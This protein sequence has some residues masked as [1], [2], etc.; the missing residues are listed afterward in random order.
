LI[1]ILAIV[2]Q[3]HIMARL[4]HEHVLPIQ[5]VFENSETKMW[6]IQTERCDGSLADWIADA[7]TR[8]LPVG[9]LCNLSHSIILGLQYLHSEG[10][11]HRDLKPSN[12][13]M[14]GSDPLIADFETSSDSTLG[15]ST[16]SRPACTPDYA[17]PEVL[18]KGQKPDHRSDLYCLGRVLHELAAA[19]AAGQL[20]SKTERAAVPASLSSLIKGLLDKDPAKRPSLAEILSRRLFRVEPPSASLEEALASSE[21][22]LVSIARMLQ[23]QS[24]RARMLQSPSARRLLAEA[25]EAAD[26]DADMFAIEVRRQT[27]SLE[28][29]GD[30]KGHVG[31]GPNV[32]VDAALRAFADMNDLRHKLRVTFTGEAGID[33]GGLTDAFYSGL[34]GAC[35][36]SAALFECYDKTTRFVLPKV[37]CCIV[38]SCFFRIFKQFVSQA[39]AD[40]KQLEVF[41]RVLI[42]MVHDRRVVSSLRRLPLCVYSFL[43]HGKEPRVS[44]GDYETVFGSA[45]SIHL[46]SCLLADQK[47]LS[48]DLCLS[49]DGLKEG[50]DK[51]CRVLCGSLILSCHFARFL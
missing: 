14:R 45:A 8:A 44:S 4:Q 48:D 7:K 25:Q 50:G 26:D 27:S 24:A 28:S 36:D 42:K 51:V 3:A 6:Y 38:Q 13:F 2:L 12:I 32:P 30:S 9:A 21:E 10:V 49:L 11:I 22:R 5:A 47:Y 34:I 46:Q 39:G 35:L 29:K 31:S 37:R 20:H 1:H 40:K 17:A 15:G 18:F 16:M 23:R 43:H 33:A 19:F 41:G